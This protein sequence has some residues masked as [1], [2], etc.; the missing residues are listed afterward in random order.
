MKLTKAEK[1][2]L[3]STLFFFALYNLPGV[4]AYGDAKGLIVHALLTVLPLWACVYLGLYHVLKQYRL[5]GRK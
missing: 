1:W 4:P 2:W 5:R 3:C